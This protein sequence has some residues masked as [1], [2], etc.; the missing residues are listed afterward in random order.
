MVW[1]NE[2]ISTYPFDNG[3]VGWWVGGVSFS[4]IFIAMSM[5]ELIVIKNVIII[6]FSDKARSE[7]NKSSGILNHEI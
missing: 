3:V 5:K 2:F 6:S 4:E 1:L 7:C